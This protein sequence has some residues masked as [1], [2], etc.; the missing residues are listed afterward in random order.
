MD[1]RRLFHAFIAARE[2]GAYD[3]FPALRDG[4]DPQVHLSRNDGPQPFFLICD[5]DTVLAPLAGTGTVEFRDSDVISY[6]L[7]PGD[8]V[9]V[10]AGMPTR[11]ASAVELVLLRFK[12][13]NPELE[14]VAWY[15][16]SC[17]AE[18][19]RRDFELGETLPQEEYFASCEQFNADELLRT[20]GGCGALHPTVDLERFAFLEVAKEIRASASSRVL[21]ASSPAGQAT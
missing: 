12:K 3:E 15:C 18:V 6:D 14:G 1:R 13:L 11:I 10:P 20:C 8:Y 7:E 17:G 16:D 21:H 4:L 2:R 19:W 5:H 9:Y